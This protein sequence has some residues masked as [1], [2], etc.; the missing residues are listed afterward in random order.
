MKIL[1]NFVNKVDVIV[2]LREQIES[3]HKIGIQTVIGCKVMYRY[4][5]NK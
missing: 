4:R 3:Q 2:L 5:V 1:I